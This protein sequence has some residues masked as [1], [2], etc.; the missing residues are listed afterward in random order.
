MPEPNDTKFMRT[1]L[2]LA[3]KG[4]GSTSPNPMVGAVVVSKGRILGRGYHKSSGAPHAEIEAFADAREKGL[5]VSRSTLYVTLEP[6]CHTEKLTPPCTEAIISSGVSR[7]VVGSVDPNPKVMGRGIEILRGAGLDVTAGVLGG[8]CSEMNECFNKHVVSG[9]PFVILKAASTLDGKIAAK[10]GDSKWIGSE[11]QRKMAHRLRREAD[12]VVVGINTVRKDDPGLNVRLG[13]RGARQPVPVIMDSRLDV[14]P[15]A[16]VFRT[17]P[18][19]VV[20]TT[21]AAETTKKERLESLGAEVFVTAPDAGGGV[22]APDLLRKL[23]RMGMCSVLVEGGSKVAAS[24]LREGLVD[25]IVFFYSP[26]IMGGDGV[27]MV[28][29]LGKKSVK[30][31]LR[32]RNVRFRRFGDEMMVEGY[33]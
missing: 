19:S 30:A 25:K 11:R 10:T 23:G 4:R 27:S 17:H 14:S 29:A 26:K 7:V 24:F 6:C 22:S 21:C 12:A 2:R 20:A 28:G 16:R 31:S 3:E 8:E 15:E 18:R 9:I 33:L 13:A 32:V 5:S 1:A